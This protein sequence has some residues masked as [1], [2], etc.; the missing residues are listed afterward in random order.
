M[1]RNVA[2]QSWPEKTKVNRG[3]FM[4]STNNGMKQECSQH[5]MTL[6]YGHIN[7]KLYKTD[8]KDV[9]KH[10]DII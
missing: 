3:K 4:V 10:T 7:T 5:D 2:S 8:L 1:S 9:H 6:F